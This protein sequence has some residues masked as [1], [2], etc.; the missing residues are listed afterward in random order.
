MLFRSA[1]HGSF[2]NR[3]VLSLPDGPNSHLPT[4][5]RLR[6]GELTTYAYHGEVLFPVRARGS[7]RILTVTSV[8]GAVGQPFADA[9]C[10]AKFAVA[11]THDVDNPWRWTRGRCP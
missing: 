7:G 10:G 2:M 6:E 4:P 11:L 1:D 8:G 9:Y 5:E 3:C